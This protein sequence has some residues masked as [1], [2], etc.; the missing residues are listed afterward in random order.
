[1]QGGV[2]SVTGHADPRGSDT[3]N[4]A[5]GLRRAQAVFE[6]ISAK[7]GPEARARLRVELRDEPAASVGT[8]GR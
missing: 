8:H 1:M 2:V 7:L 3:Y 5:L 4:T 6:A